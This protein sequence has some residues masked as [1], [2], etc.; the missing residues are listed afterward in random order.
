[1]K[2]FLISSKLGSLLFTLREKFNLLSVFVTNKDTFQTEYNDYLA[3]KI[4]KSLPQPNSTFIDI[5]SHIGSIISLIK[6]NN[7]EV[8]IFGIEAIPEKVRSLKKRFPEVTFF[9]CA[10][11]EKEGTAAFYVDEE[12]SGYSSLNKSNS[13]NKT[14]TISVELKTLD[15]LINRDE[16]DTI[17]IDVEGAELS[18]LKGA[19]TLLHKSRPTIMF[20]SGPKD[21]IEIEEL[22]L[23]FK[24]ANYSIFIPNRLAHF[25]P[26]MSKEVFK[27]SHQYPRLTTN[28]FAVANDNLSDVRFKA[29]EILKIK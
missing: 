29:R 5:G 10:L 4:L 11:A 8:E 6:F 15:S 21:D 3:I 9:E 27:D 28:Y 26:G 13:N 18:V 7:P 14:R 23:L 12:M 16:V 19:N 22:W 2:P 24:D 17:K 20:E 1:M 25:A